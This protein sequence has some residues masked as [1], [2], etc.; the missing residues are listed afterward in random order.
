MQKDKRRGSKDAQEKVRLLVVDFLKKKKGSQQECS[1][2]YGLTLNGVQKI[3]Y[4]YRQK[5]SRGLA[6]KK[7]GVQ[8]GKK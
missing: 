7:R 8:G 3:W 5:G 2:L 6:S 1:L 4:R